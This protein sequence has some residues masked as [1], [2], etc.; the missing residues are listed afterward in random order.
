M[1]ETAG[2]PAGIL[3]Y[4]SILLFILLLCQKIFVAPEDWARLIT[5]MTS[6]ISFELACAATEK[7]STLT[8]VK[9]VA[10]FIVVFQIIILGA[11]LLGT[12]SDI[13]Q[14]LEGV[15]NETPADVFVKYVATIWNSKICVSVTIVLALWTVS[16]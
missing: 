7:F 1:R 12:F 9:I 10:L 4:F 15:D 14:T 2:L 5:F 13:L 6:A 16:K 11:D 8:G 3:A